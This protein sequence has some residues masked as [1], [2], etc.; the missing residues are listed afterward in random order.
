MTGDTSHFKSH[1]PVKNKKAWNTMSDKQYRQAVFP[2]SPAGLTLLWL[3]ISVAVQALGAR[4]RSSP[5]QTMGVASGHAAATVP[6][7]L[8]NGTPLSIAVVHRVRIGHQGEPVQGTLV[9][10]VYSFDRVVAPAGS[11][12][13]GR[14]AKV[15]SAPRKK[16]IEAIMQGNFTPLRSAQ[17]GFD[18]LVLKNG[19]CIPIQ[20]HVSPATAQVVHLQ[21]VDGQQSGKKGSISRAVSNAKQQIEAEKKQVLAE[22]ERPGRMHRIK[23]WLLA[24]LPYHHQYLPAGAR[25]TAV[26][27]KPVT[28]GSAQV[29]ASE[30]KLVGSAP[31]ANSLL[32]AVLIT[33]LSSATARRG[34]PVEAMVTRPLFSKNHELI[35]PEGSKLE[36]RV[37]KSEPARRM[38]LHRNGILRFTFQKIQT[39]HGIPHIVEGNLQGVDVA[40]KERV[41]L[42]SEGG[43]HSKTSKMHY[44]EPALAVLIAAT[45]AMPDTDVRPGRVYTDTNGPASSQILGGGLGFGFTGVVMA[46]GVHAQPVT[47]GFAAYGAAWSI[48][49][50][51]LS[52]GQDI[53]FP[54]DTP[55]EIRLGRTPAS[56]AVTQ[57]SR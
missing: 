26:V 48:Y 5:P 49:S 45:S 14:I 7:S 32:E 29:A 11:E 8:Q 28:L 4:L 12:V 22:L 13:L 52:Q 41:V 42:D 20:T 39:P 2:W 31:P 34:T 54:K 10:P 9:Q 30:L 46:L 51:L 33:P 27:E 17:V 37:V 19:R 55:M 56:N 16:R 36:G 23:Q 44:A 53:V 24:G 57:N 18:T 6:L 38:R 47:A 35:I 3:F 1:M 15:M 50:Q 21:V 25:F 40:K 43:A